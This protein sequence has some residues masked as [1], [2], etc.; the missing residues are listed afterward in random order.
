ML[1]APSTSLWNTNQT[2]SADN[3][4]IKPCGFHLSWHQTHSWR[5]T[6]P[7]SS[8]LE[9]LLFLQVQPRGEGTCS[10]SCC[11]FALIKWGNQP[12][13]SSI[14]KSCLV[15]EASEASAFFG[16]Q[17]WGG[18]EQRVHN[19]LHRFHCTTPAHIQTPLWREA[20]GL[21][22]APRPLLL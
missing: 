4:C 2:V 12:G 20:G 7:L 6:A 14:F 11:L 19:L 22:L 9:F 5:A 8:T 17:Q 15:L 10:P 16:N 21:A 3:F 13:A 1:M 18:G